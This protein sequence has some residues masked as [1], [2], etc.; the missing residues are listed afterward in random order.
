MKRSVLTPRQKVFVQEYLVDFNATQ[1]AARAG[2]TGKNAV[3]RAIASENLT[4]P[5]VAAAVADALRKRK[6][7]AEIRA[8]DI[9]EELMRCGFS[10]MKDYATWGPQ[11]VKLI[12]SK[13]LGAKSRAVAEVKETNFKGE[14]TITF[15]LHDKVGALDRLARHLGMYAESDGRAFAQGAVALDMFRQM[16]EDARKRPV[17]DVAVTPELAPANGNGSDNGGN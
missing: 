7:D 2:Y 16:V 6:E 1:A 17:I 9:K 10:D 11:G 14:R 8:E 13:K 5:N 12:D 3:L 15:K 4:K